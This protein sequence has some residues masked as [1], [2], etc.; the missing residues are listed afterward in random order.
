MKAHLLIKSFG[1][2]LTFF[3]SMAAAGQS[4]VRVEHALENACN[5]NLRY[6]N[7]Q[8]LVDSVVWSTGYVGWNLTDVPP[9]TYGYELFLDGSVVAHFRYHI[10]LARSS[11][12]C[13]A[14][15]TRQ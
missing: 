12:D 15:R 6:Y 1:C 10:A 11:L 2:T 9:G 8:E 13:V 14:I 7:E 3:A 4:G 5:G